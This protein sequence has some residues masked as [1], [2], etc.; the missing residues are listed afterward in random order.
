LGQ[1]VTV[2]GG[3]TADTFALDVPDETA[4]VDSPLTHIRGVITNALVEPPP[5][6]GGD[7]TV[8]LTV[9]T[10]RGPVQVRVPETARS[11]VGASDLPA[12]PR[13][14]V[15]AIGHTVSI[16][17]GLDEGTGQV[18]TDALVLGPKAER[19]VR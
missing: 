17:G 6:G 14:L 10:L 3:P 5:A 19:P 4:P 12:G 8:V 18:V 11:F 15:R 7:P 2:T 9:Q 1:R 13:L 16:T